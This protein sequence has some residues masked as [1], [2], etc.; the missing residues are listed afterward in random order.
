MASTPLAIV[1]DRFGSKEK[2]VKAVEGLASKDLWLDRVNEEKGLA[3]V[4][5]A[6][7]IRLHDTLEDAKKRFGS[8]DKLISVICKIEKREK[9][10]GYKTR[11]GSYP[12]PR[13][14]D[15]HDAADKR[16]KK[17]KKAAPAKKKLARSK[18][19]QAKTAAK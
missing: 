2:L 3:R 16:A 6:K 19:A 1:K 4:S 10:D 18:K 12:L 14:V 13:L 5:N 17:P 7:L 11:L 15:L 8:R 9:D